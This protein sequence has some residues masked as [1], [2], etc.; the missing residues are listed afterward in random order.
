MY[1]FSVEPKNQSEHLR[2]LSEYWEIT[3]KAKKR[4]EWMIFYNTVGKKNSKYTASYFG[5]APKTFHKW[6][7][8]FNPHIIQSLEEQ[9]RTP[10]K[11]RIWEVTN[12]QEKRIIDLRNR[13]LKYGKKKLKVLYFQDYHESV[14]TWKI[15]RV[16]RK[17]NLYPDL[18]EHKKRIRKM[19]KRKFKPRLRIH[20]FRTQPFKG[21]LWHTDS[22]ILWWYGTRRVIFTA[23][24]DK[25][26][27]GYARIYKTNSS[28]KAVD[29]LKRL[30]YLSDGDINIIHSDNGSEFAGEFEKAC[31]KLDITQIYSR[32]RT[33][34]DNP[35]LERFNRTLQEEWLELSEVGLDE[36]AEGNIDLSVWLIEYNSHRPHESLD[37][38]TPL[39]YAQRQYFKE[40]PMWSAGTICFISNQTGRYCL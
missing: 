2:N 31:I 35:C 23:I 30:I 28:R 21:T 27:L 20:E 32:V 5:I 13:Y 1:K 12:I 29:F 25:T 22:I 33:P 18:S 4:L 34:N 15:E 6:K 26:K 7:K 10:K 16:I 39:E 17:H 9:S 19:Q 11:K 37:Y 8:R 14:S 36:I 24:E 38:L 40:L 3:S